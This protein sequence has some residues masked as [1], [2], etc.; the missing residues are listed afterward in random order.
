MAQIKRKMRNGGQ[1]REKYIAIYQKG[2]G[3][4]IEKN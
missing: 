4:L 3:I 2:H 1:A